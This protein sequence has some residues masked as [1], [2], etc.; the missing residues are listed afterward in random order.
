MLEVNQ[1]THVVAIWD[2]ASGEIV[3]YL[4]GQ[5]AVT[6]PVDGTLPNTG[7]PRNTTNAMFVGRDNRNTANL[8]ATIDEVAVYNYALRGAQ[9]AT[10]YAAGGASLANLIQTDVE[11]SMRA[12]GSSGYLRIPF[13]VPADVMFDQLLLTVRYDDGFAAYL[14]GVEVARRNAPLG[15][16]AYDSTATTA[17]NFA[18]V[19][20][21]DTIDLSHVISLLT[22]GDNVLAI[23]G[24]NVLVQDATFLVQAHLDASGFPEQTGGL[25]PVVFSELT[26]ADPAVAWIEWMNESP[27]AISLKDFVL[28]CDGETP[29]RVRLPAVSIPARLPGAG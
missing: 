22:P 17:R 12:V 23:H 29:H 10:H 6:T 3:V 25:P 28:V 20:A 24:L 9:A 14:N 4:D 27:Q 2:Q 18:E 21:A 15:M 16:L 1:V 19:L 8:Q 5:V 7:S 26:A 13:D 11:A